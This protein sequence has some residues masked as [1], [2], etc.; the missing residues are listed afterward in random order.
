MLTQNQQL[1]MTGQDLSK[2]PETCPFVQATPQ[3]MFDDYGKEIDGCSNEFVDIFAG[4]PGQQEYKEEQ[5]KNS[6]A[7][8]RFSKPMFSSERLTVDT[9]VVF[10]LA[11]GQKPDTELCGNHVKQQVNSQQW[12]MHMTEATRKEWDPGTLQSIMDVPAL[13]ELSSSEGLPHAVIF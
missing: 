3:R 11:T 8:K 7:L 9:V 13:V 5:H 1:S 2:I 10:S 12:N 4:S 6:Q